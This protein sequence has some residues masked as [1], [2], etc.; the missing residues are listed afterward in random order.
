MM[1]ADEA[2]KDETPVVVKSDTADVRR[3]YSA[4][5][6]RYLGTVYELTLTGSGSGSEFVLPKPRAS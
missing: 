3:P 5:S 1:R 4:P 2:A 6:L